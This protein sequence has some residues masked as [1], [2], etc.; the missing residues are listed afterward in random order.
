MRRVTQWGTR[1]YLRSW[2]SRDDKEDGES[3]RKKEKENDA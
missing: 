3:Y 2:V 1:G